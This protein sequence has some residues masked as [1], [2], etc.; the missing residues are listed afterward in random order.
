VN[1]G[2]LAKTPMAPKKQKG[3][4]KVLEPII[5]SDEHVNFHY[6]ESNGDVNFLITPL[7]GPRSEK[8]GK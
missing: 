1:M 7:D 6:F 4:E 2:S 3:K 8:W 5:K